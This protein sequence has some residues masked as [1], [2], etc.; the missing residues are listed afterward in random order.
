MSILDTIKES[1]IAQM[2]L[3]VI[4]PWIILAIIV[5]IYDYQISK[6]VVNPNALYGII[7][8]DYGEI[9]GYGVIAIGLSVLIGAKN[10]DIKKYIRKICCKMCWL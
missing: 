2:L 1:K 10:D 3:I 8:A 6:A 4:I 7:G 5:G 9:P